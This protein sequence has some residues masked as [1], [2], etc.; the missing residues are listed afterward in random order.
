MS[1]TAGRRA[2]KGPKPV[3]HMGAKPKRND[4]RKPFVAQARLGSLE[5][6]AEV[7]ACGNESFAQR[8]ARRP[9]ADFRHVEDAVGD[10]KHEERDATQHRPSH[11]QRILQEQEHEAPDQRAKGN[12]EAQGMRSQAMDPG[13]PG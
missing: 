8:N 13:L 9:L 7:L 10:A 6:A 1:K 4:I 3:I 12:E 2:T 5:F 11:P